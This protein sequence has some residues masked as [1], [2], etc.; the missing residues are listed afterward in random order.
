MIVAGFGFRAAA[1][2]DSLAGALRAA[3]NSPVDAVA[4]P[5]DK[6][7]S[8]VFVAF[9]RE[10]GVPLVSVTADDM[11]RAET[12]T[13][14]QLVMKKRGTGSVAEAVAL[15]AAGNGAELTGPRVVSGDRMATCAIAVGEKT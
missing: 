10:L 14:S 8:D 5:V 7:G 15:A 4:A 12:L 6:C 13:K 2:G 1:T 9:A 11:Q 3:T